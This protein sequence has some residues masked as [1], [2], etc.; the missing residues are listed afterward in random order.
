MQF[1]HSRNNNK[2]NTSTSPKVAKSVYI[3]MAKYNTSKTRPTKS[4]LQT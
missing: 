2:N 3:V 4:H 1:Y